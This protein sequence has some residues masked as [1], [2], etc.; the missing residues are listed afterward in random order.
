[1]ANATY[2]QPLIPRS[3]RRDGGLDTDLMV[4]LRRAQPARGPRTG[5]TGRSRVW[6]S[7]R[8]RARRGR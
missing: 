4:V 7:W 1:R 2:A 8:G 3:E 5:L 6:R